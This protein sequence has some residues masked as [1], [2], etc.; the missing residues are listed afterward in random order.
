MTIT[1]RSSTKNGEG[2]C[3]YCG[4]ADIKGQHHRLKDAYDH[5]LPK[6][7]YPFNSV[8]FKNLAPMCHECN[9]SYKLAKEP[10][11]QNSPW[12]WTNEGK[13]FYSYATA[14]STISINLILE[15][16]GPRQN[17]PEQTSTLMSP[18]P[19]RDEELDT[20][21]DPL[22]D[23]RALQGQVLR[24]ERWQSVASEGH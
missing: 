24:Q 8:N 7:I 22:W 16:G 19:D 1:K 3:P 12:T 23:R 5:Y 14:A 11:P 15:A 17:L 13:A 10:A 2:K 18:L 9:S 4:I 6:S 21:K 20:W